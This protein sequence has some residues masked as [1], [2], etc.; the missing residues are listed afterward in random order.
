MFAILLFLSKK[1]PGLVTSKI[2]RFVL[3]DLAYAWITVNG[4]LL[5]YGVSLSVTSSN[6]LSGA[7]IAGILIFVAYLVVMAVVS[8]RS[9]F[10]GA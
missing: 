8:F 5:A 9:F 10:R 6:S 7:D 3:Y 2:K 1:K 4:F